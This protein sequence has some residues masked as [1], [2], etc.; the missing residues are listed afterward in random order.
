M[1]GR[2]T[3]WD[4]YS[5]TIQTKKFLFYYQIEKDTLFEMAEPG[6]VDT[7]IQVYNDSTIER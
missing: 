4:K 1:V 5:I 2:I 7:L 6:R 3:K